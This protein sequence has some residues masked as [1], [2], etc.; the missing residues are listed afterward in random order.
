MRV[1][2]HIR[3]LTDPEKEQFEAYLDK[4]LERVHRL[5]EKDYPDKDTLKFDAHIEKHDKHTAFELKYV[6]H[7]PSKQLVASATKHSVTEPMDIATD[8]LIR[9][10]KRHKELA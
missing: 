10:I 9:E 4:K 1:H 7:L 8:S 2:K 5:L 3:N 6:L